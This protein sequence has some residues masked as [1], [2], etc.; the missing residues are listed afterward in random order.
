[1]SEA[2]NRPPH[3]TFG[4]F[5]VIEVLED[6]F[7]S[8]PLLWQVG[9]YIARAMH[10]GKPLEDLKKARYY[11]DRRIRHME[12]TAQGAPESELRAIDDRAP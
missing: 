10:K 7:P 12:A 5:E 1:M 8:D 4:R 6:W 9:K 3:Y 2:V 11:L